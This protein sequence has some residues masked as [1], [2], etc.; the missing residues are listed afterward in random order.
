[1]NRRDLDGAEHHVVGKEA[2]ISPA[3]DG[4]LQT[5]R[6]QIEIDGRAAGVVLTNAKNMDRSVNSSGLYIGFRRCACY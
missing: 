2:A 5:G 4:D 1:M 3:P 6:T